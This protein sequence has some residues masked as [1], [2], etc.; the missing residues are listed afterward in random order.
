[1]LPRVLLVE[2]RT[3][4]ADH[5]FVGVDVTSPATSREVQV[6]RTTIVVASEARI[7]L[8]R[9]FELVSRLLFVIELKVVT[10]DVPIFR[11]VT[12]STVTRK[13]FMRHHRPPLAAPTLTRYERVTVECHD[14]PRKEQR[15]R[16]GSSEH[17]LLVRRG[18][19]HGNLD[20]PDPLACTARR[21]C[22]RR[23]SLASDNPRT[24]TWREYL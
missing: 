11:V 24:P 15:H 5:R 12:D 16:S 3:V 1:M 9:A 20:I 10:H 22:R 17:S 7:E 2:T 18:G 23:A 4:H 19:F 14:A 21:H 6:H 13:G 8:V